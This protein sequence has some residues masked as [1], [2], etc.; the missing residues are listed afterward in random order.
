MIPTLGLPGAIASETGGGGAEEWRSDVG[1]SRATFQPAS[2][3]QNNRRLG[4]REQASASGPTSQTPRAWSRSRAMMANGF[5]CRGLRS[6]SR[7]IAASSR[8]VNH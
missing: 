4:R 2:S 6:R 5:S 1:F 7:L 3:Q 8:T